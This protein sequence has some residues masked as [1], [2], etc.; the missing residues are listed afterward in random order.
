MHLAIDA[1]MVG[2]RETGNETYIIN[3][4]QGLLRQF[5]E[6]NYHLFT[7]HK[8]D[9]TRHL[10]ANS[11]AK[12]VDVPPNPLIRIP[13]VIPRALQKNQAQLLHVTYIAP[14]SLPCPV[15]VTIHDIS[16]SLFPE[17]FSLR[18]RLILSMLVPLTAR[19]ATAII[20]SSKKTRD[21]LITRYGISQQKITVTHLSFNK[22]FQTLNKAEAEEFVAIHYNIRQDF[23][24][25]LGNLQPRKNLPR[26]IEAY[27]RLKR[28]K[29][30]NL[31]LV[32]AG[33]AQWRESEIY[34][35]IKDAGVEQEVIFTGYIPHEHLPWLYNAA[36]F[37]VYPSLYEGFG[38]PP[39]EAM[40]CGTPVICA[41]TGAL[42]EVVGKAALTFNP[43]N[44]DDMTQ[45]IFIM[46]S[47]D[48]LRSTLGLKGLQQAQQF[49]W[50]KTAR[51]TMAL[52]QEIINGNSGPYG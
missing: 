27:A 3:L 7:C 1:H 10:P 45:K 51:E 47:S 36:S 20:A 4:I 6:H 37:F 22:R 34:Q 15:V 5:P 11:G 42:P 14:P 40:A 2:E 52:Y 26:L 38:L 39:L 35:T 25:T 19:R 44:L 33:Q 17:F 48:E 29:K 43:Y 12:L 23:I 24:L 49:S 46:A 8:A 30:L 21:D 28:A 32:I 9:L 50:D 16:Y 13:F 18:D 31:L 41:N